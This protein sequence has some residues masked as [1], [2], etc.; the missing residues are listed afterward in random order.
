MPSILRIVCAVWLLLGCA[1]ASA[2]TN[3]PLIFAA[4]SL[5]EALDAV[6]LA[7]GQPAKLA[8]AGSSA[9]AKQI[10]AGAPVDLFISAD[11]AW[12][13]YVAERNLIVPESRITLLGNRLVLVAPTSG[14]KAVMLDAAA[15]LIALNG[16]RLALADPAAVPAGK[17]AKAAF[18]AL[19]LWSA[20]EPHFVAAD[21]VRATLALVARAEAPLGVVYATDAAAEPRVQVVATFAAGSHPPIQYPVALLADAPHPQQARALLDFLTTPQA[22][23]IFQ[24]HGFTVPPEQ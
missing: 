16:G 6:I 4:A 3:P 12:M 13:A 22:T 8:Y 10:E 14:P 24:R 21:N 1:P 19:G 2:Q 15:M 18:A 23:R 17:Y 7:W 5:K 11:L 9:L 20:L